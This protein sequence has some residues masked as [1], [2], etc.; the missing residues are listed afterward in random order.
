MIPIRPRSGM[1]R[2]GLVIVALLHLV[3]TAALPFTHTHAPADRFDEVSAGPHEGEGGSAHGHTA[4]TICRTLA[5][6][7]AAPLLPTVAA[8]PA[9]PET[10]S[11]SDAEGRTTPA[12]FTSSRPRAP[13]HA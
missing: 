12:T 2:C 10:V 13:P 8:A 1:V 7:Q 5:G 6:A 4:C 11:S 3:A 9:L